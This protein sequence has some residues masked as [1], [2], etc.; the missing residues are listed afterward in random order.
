MAACFAEDRW[1]SINDA[2]PSVGRQAIAAAAQEFM[3]AFPDMVVAMDGVDRDGDRCVYRWTL[4]GPSSGAGGSGHGVRMSGNGQWTIG[5]DGLIRQ[6]LG[7]STRPG[8]RSC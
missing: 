8:T 1:L 2:A 5:A 3:T 4:T 7:R 6:S